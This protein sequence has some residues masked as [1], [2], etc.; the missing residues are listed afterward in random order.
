[1]VNSRL[2][3]DCSFFRRPKAGFDYQLK[4]QSGSFLSAMNLLIKAKRSHSSLINSPVTRGLARWGWRGSESDDLSGSAY[5][6]ALG[7]AVPSLVAVAVG[8][9]LGVAV[10]VGVGVEFR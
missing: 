2:V 1:M 8:V 7:L 5:S 6:S 3:D 9:A 4:E 10:G